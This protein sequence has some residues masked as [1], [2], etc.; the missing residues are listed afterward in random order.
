MQKKKV[1]ICSFSATDAK[2]IKH[3][4]C[5]KVEEED[6]EESYFR[7][8]LIL[9]KDTD[10]IAENLKILTPYYLRYV[11]K[12]REIRTYLDLFPSL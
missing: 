6:T 1:G 3:A 9:S 4:K 5:A 10:Y 7:S 8:Q 2:L 11:S 12:D